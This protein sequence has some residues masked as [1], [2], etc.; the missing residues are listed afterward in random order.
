[1]NPPSAKGK[2]V[3]FF[4]FLLVIDWWLYFRHAAH[5]FQGDT[6]FLLS[7]RATTLAGY[8]NEFIALNPSGWYRPLA[9][10]VF[11]SLLY[12]F[13]GLHPIPYRIPVYVVYVA[14]TAAVY[15]LVLTLTKRHLTSAL[16]TLFFTI[17]TT[18]VY[19]TYDL[20]F[21]PEL[22]YA[23]F[24]VV[25]VLAYL[26][27]LETQSKAAYRVSLGCFV[28]GLLS[29]EAAVTLPGVLFVMGLLLGG[30]TGS[31]S[32]R[33]IRT[34]RSIMPHIAVLILYLAL[35]IGYLDVQGVSVRKMFDPSQR[36]AAGDYVPVLNGGVLTN[37]DHA[38]SWAFNIPRG[39]ATSAGLSPT[40]V[41]CLKL[42]RALLLAL[43]VF[44][45]IK[46]DRRGVLLGVLWFWITLLPA[47]PLVA[48]FLPYYLFLPSVGLSLIAGAAFVWLYDA[49][50]RIH[51]AVAAAVI[52]LAF[53]GLLYASS[54]SARAQIR[55]NAILGESARTGF[56]TLNDLKRLYPTLPSKSVLFFLDGHEPL[57]WH[58][59]SGGLIRMAYGNDE[60]SALYESADGV[61]PEIPGVIVLSVSNG[62]LT[63]ETASYR[64]NPLKFAKLA[65]S[66]FKFALSTPQVA[67]GRDK[68][69]LSVPQLSNTSIRVAYTI[70]DGPLETFGVTLDSEG[71]VTLDVS[72]N[73]RRGLYRFEAFKIADGMDWIRIGENLTVY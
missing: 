37:A 46:S 69:T 22:L 15:A 33:F 57:S 73:T 71:K 27:Y 48:H 5:F 65:P 42:F 40:M 30:R 49:M 56:D 54:R 23:F 29:K 50:R 28:A 19:A 21:M 10:E 3:A 16:A 7:H 47:L 68:Y 24:Y 1:M 43:T 45:L 66:N 53:G 31:F 51:P 67:A 9:N 4:A 61:I 13:A 64:R 62:R 26:R 12:P 55:D 25:A 35:A 60:I 38:M 63:D 17:H 59:D 32:E 18:S 39:A 72:P 36:P 20:G 34:A 58:H 2:V 14:M 52:V 6:V 8:W 11:E 41:L 70:D 44:A